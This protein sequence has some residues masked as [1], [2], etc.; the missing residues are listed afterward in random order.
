MLTHLD[1]YITRNKK[2]YYKNTTSQS[3]ADFFVHEVNLRDTVEPTE[4]P[5]EAPTE[6]PT[7]NPQAIPLETMLILI[8]SAIAI[9]VVLICGIIVCCCLKRFNKKLKKVSK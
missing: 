1:Q 2:N 8:V 9:F 3:K 7:E 5:T 4:A 6:Q